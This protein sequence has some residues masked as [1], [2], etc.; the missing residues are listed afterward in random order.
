MFCTFCGANI[1]DDAKFCSKCGKPTVQGSPTPQ[2]ASVA[3][4]AQ[5]MDQLRD[6][7]KHG[8]EYSKNGARVMAEYNKWAKEKWLVEAENSYSK[9]QSFLNQ[10]E[11]LPMVKGRS[12]AERQALMVKEFEYQRFVVQ[13]GTGLTTVDFYRKK[14]A[15]AVERAH[16]LLTETLPNDS[17]FIKDVTALRAQVLAEVRSKDFALWK[18]IRKDIMKDE[19]RPEELSFGEKMFG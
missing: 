10:I 19:V 11:E 4:N 7:V 2:E 8:L 16:R 14:Y 12:A 1:P 13:I 15:Q 3:S 17:V 18:T 9:A 5:E 6:L